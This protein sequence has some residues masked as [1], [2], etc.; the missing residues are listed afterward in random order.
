VPAARVEG[1]CVMT[2]GALYDRIGRGYASQ[3][4]PDARI[5]AEIIRALGKARTVVN[6]GAGTGSYEPE[7]REVV[8]VDPSAVMLRQRRSGAA[9]AVRGIAEALPFPD[10][11]FDAALA[12][13]SVHH[14]SD[15]EAGLRELRRVTRRQVV[16][17]WDPDVQARFWFVHQYLPEWTRHEASKATLSRIVAALPEPRVEP[18][19]IPH[20]CS[21][22][23]G[24]AYWRRPW[25]YLDAEVR[26]SSSV[27]SLLDPVVIQRATERLE[28]DLRSGAWHERNRELLDLHEF[29]GGYRLVIAGGGSLPG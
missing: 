7:D 25:A 19:L 28:A 23:F 9:P 8:A 21:D 24:G 29:D 17:T 20:D 3:R 5:A 6:V 22:G 13:L 1:T 2:T 10:W 15:P 4:R 16:L 18:L 27:L 11:S 26:A 14:W 12:L